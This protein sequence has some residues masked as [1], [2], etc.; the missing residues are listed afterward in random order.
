MQS[1]TGGIIGIAT[2]LLLAASLGSADAGQRQIKQTFGGTFLSTRIDLF[3]IGNPDGVVA[4]WSTIEVA[5]NLQSENH[6][7][8][9]VSEDVPTGPTQDCP[10]G[11]FIIDAQNGQGFGAITDTYRKGDQLYSQLLTSTTC[12]DSVG[13]FTNSQTGIF[14]GGTGKFAGASGTFEASSTGFFQVFDPVANQGFG[15]FTGNLE[16]TLILP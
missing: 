12:A 6:R 7:A 10:G 13:R 15:S 3:P 11:V 4:G 16:G 5:D 14:V 9:V 2:G 8:Q 1:R